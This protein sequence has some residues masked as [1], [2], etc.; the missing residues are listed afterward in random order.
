[1]SAAT[2]VITETPY[3]AVDTHALQVLESS[4]D[5]TRLLAAVDTLDAVRTRLYDPE[6]LRDDLLRLHGI[7]HT[8]INGASP[9]V[10]CQ[11]ESVVDL[12]T[13]AMDQIDQHVENLLALRDTL[14]PL[15]ML[16]PDDAD[17]FNAG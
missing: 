11:R 3:G 16:R 2:S 15:E 4:Y 13:D 9:A 7:A 6:G 8:L 17:A 1:M 5:T 10:P 14:Q 12:L